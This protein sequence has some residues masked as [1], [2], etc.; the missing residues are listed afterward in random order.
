MKLPD[1]LRG[2]A[3]FYAPWFVGPVGTRGMPTLWLPNAVKVQN[4][5]TNDRMFI[6]EARVGI[7]PASTALQAAA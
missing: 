6:M 1:S 2:Q 7:E 5:P 4:H 3:V